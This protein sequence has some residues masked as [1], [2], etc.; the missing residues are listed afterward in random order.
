MLVLLFKLKKN[1]KNN[2][3]ELKNVKASSLKRTV[4]TFIKKSNI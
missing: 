4:N 3:E 2:M 1:I